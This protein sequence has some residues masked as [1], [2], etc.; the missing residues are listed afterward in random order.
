[1]K[2]V[3]SD[4]KIP[5]RS[6]YLPVGESDLPNALTWDT[7]RPAPF[8][9]NSIDPNLLKK[10][11]EAN[12]SRQ[13]TLEEFSFL[14]D[15]INW[16][17][18]KQDEVSISLNLEERQKQKMFDEAFREKMEE[19]QTELA[20]LNYPKT[21]IQLDSVIKSSIGE[22]E[23]TEAANE[24]SSEEKEIPKFDIHLREALR[25]LTDTLDIEPDT[26]HW[27]LT[28]QA[29]IHRESGKKVTR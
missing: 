1:M 3:V 12:Q 21:E 9:Q 14:T 16:Y 29:T 2:G 13:E 27:E 17:R 24:D 23:K 18:L 28:A 25:I 26:K 22:E 11:R 19:R 20:K 4:I 6:E 7:I 8:A 10:L 5:S 15:R